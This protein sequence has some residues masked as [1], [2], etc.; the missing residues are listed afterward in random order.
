M[1][2]IDNTH[3]GTIVDS[4]W[5][6]QEERLQNID[7]IFDREQMQSIT[8]KC[9]YINTHN[10]IDKITYTD[11]PLEIMNDRSI[12]TKEKLIKL[13]QDNKLR[14]KD[15]AYKLMD[16]LLC[17]FDII[18]SAI[19][20]FSSVGDNI[21]NI[22]HCFKSV[23]SVDDVIIQPSTFIFHDINSMYI[24]FQEHELV[25]N[26]HQIK[27]IL[28][29]SDNTQKRKHTKKVRITLSNDRNRSNLKN[30]ITRRRLK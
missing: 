29:A 27:S 2:D 25:K 28:K 26:G 7:S 15:A 22:D 11:V 14:T 6:Q 10:Y 18:P 3:L 19:Q 9:I 30:R 21:N 20:S 4:R 17:N 1:T 24:L 8:V 16:V 12:L 23:S 5:L 13:I